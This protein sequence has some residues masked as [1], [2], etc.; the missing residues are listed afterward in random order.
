MR[1]V[2]VLFDVSI[3]NML[4]VDFDLMCLVV[5]IMDVCNEEICVML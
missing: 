3:L 4:N 1:L 2:V 5:G